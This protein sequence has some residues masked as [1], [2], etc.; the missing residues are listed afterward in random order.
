MRDRASMRF[1]IVILACL[2]MAV[3]FAATPSDDA[4]PAPDAYAYGWPIELEA[5]ADFYEFE[6]PLE[7]YRSVADP[8]L[9]DIGVYNA[10]GEPVPRLISAPANPGAAPEKTAEISALPIYAPPGT[11]LGE[12]RLALER[13]DGGTSVRI[14][15]DTLA[16]GT[17]PKVLV[18]YIADLGRPA[19]DLRAIELEWP[20]EIEPLVTQLTVE[21]SADLDVWFA[22]GSGAIAGL[23][24][25]EANIERRRVELGTR[26][27]RYLRLSWRA[28]PEGWRVTRLLAHHSQAAPEAEHEWLTLWPTGRDTADGGYLYD[29]GGSPLIDRLTLA[30]PG[31]NSLVRASVYARASLEERWQRVHN[32]LFYRLRREGDAVTNESVAHAPQRAARWKVVV[33]RGQPELRLGLTLGWRRD[34]VLFVAQGEAPWRLV[35]G[36]ARDAEDYFPQAR[37]FSDPEM[38]KLLE[39]TGPV[40]VAKLGK[41]EELGGPL[42]LESPHSP[43]WRRW[44]L[45]LGLVA[46]VLLV[47]GMAWRLGRQP[48]GTR[49]AS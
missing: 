15:T 38:R 27:V 19:T 16:A 40:G 21:G 23:R 32:G 20:R 35:A 36:S 45:W 39:D 30:L 17:E 34:R 3:A 13:S 4:M 47:G 24:Q 29:M 12:L 28:V 25:D 7:V 48:A 2:A 44:L 18:A 41:R 9:R 5:P 33:E 49:N 11:P 6:L 43:A 22:M 26:E 8:A 37:R 46:G 42:R 14:E 31:E 10:R 1:Q